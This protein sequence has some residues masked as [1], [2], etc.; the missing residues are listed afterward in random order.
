[1]QLAPYQNNAIQASLD[2]LVF[3]GIQRQLVQM[4]TG[5]GKTIY[6]GGLAQAFL[7]PGQRML[8]VAHRE[9]ILEHA[10]EEFAHFLPHTSMGIVQADRDEC[11][12]SYVFGMIQTIQNPERLTRILRHGPIALLFVDECHRALAPTWR[13]MI[14][15]VMTPDTLLVGMT[16]TPMRSDH[17][18]LRT[19]FQDCVYSIGILDL[20]ALDPPLLC[21]LRRIQVVVP[22]LSLKS[23]KRSDAGDFDE[24][25][26]ALAVA[27]SRTRHRLALEAIH[28]YAKTDG[29]LWPGLAF[30]VDVADAI[31]FAK[32]ANGSGIPAAVIHG[33]TPKPERDAILSAFD[34]GDIKLIVNVN[35]F[36]E[37]IDLPKARYVVVLRHTTSQ[38]LYI[39]IVGR[40]SRLL[41]GE[42]DLP[43]DQRTKKEGLIFDV[44]DNDHSVIVLADM[45]GITDEKMGHKSIRELIEKKEIRVTEPTEVHYE[46]GNVQLRVAHNS[47]YTTRP[48]KPVGRDGKAWELV[49]PG[50]GR[51]IIEN[52]FGVYSAFFENESRK[53]Q[54]IK[55]G[56]HA[57][58]RPDLMFGIGETHLR[59]LEQNAQYR[60]LRR[61]DDPTRMRPAR[62]DQLADI[63]KRCPLF[64]A[65]TNYKY[66]RAPNQGDI[67]DFWDEIKQH[68]MKGWYA[69]HKNDLPQR[70]RTASRTLNKGDRTFE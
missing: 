67:Q 15:R 13:H 10:M 38:G 23:L 40:V 59:G 28:R 45:I 52:D 51:V 63:K 22:D 70:K 12:K 57:F 56:T 17:R 64:L 37:G 29:E 44:C 43:L 9:G 14:E 18:S 25:E 62:P 19:I 34:E 42:R 53:R 26:L 7:Q 55:A 3:E 8:Y 49:S 5:A 54:A 21:D 31:A 36:T 1:M 46:P 20:I 32:L 41:K 69:N 6:A 11:D 30:C 39:Q 27:K 35:V 47:V 48:W 24:Q 58:R 4:A 65:I 50:I 16:A 33:K 61:H 66:H 68:G 2:A 60:D